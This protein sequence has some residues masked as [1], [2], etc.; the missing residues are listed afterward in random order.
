MTAIY[1]Q[2]LITYIY[3]SHATPAMQPDDMSKIIQLSEKHNPQLEVTGLLTYGGGM[4]LQ[5]LEGPHH[6]VHEL[7]GWIRK[8][9]RHE[10]I[11]QLHSASGLDNRLYPNWSME[12]VAPHD[13]QN[14]LEQAAERADSTRHAEAISLL[15]QL[16]DEGALAPLKQSAC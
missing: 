10:C 3:C 11:L 14:V 16:F 2:D 12:L 6:A 1:R 15:L 8:D 7:M 4:F 9:P 13:I 5:W